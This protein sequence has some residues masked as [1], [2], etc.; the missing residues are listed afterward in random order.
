MPDVTKL[1]HENVIKNF[2]GEGH[3]LPVEADMRLGVAG[4]PESPLASEGHFLGL[5]PRL[6]SPL[7]EAKTEDFRPHFF[8]EFC[9]L[10]QSLP[11]Q[12][13]RGFVKQLKILRNIYH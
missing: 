9:N 13:L 2:L 1:M 12:F 8:V 11:S 10:P 4:A 6:L 5:K 7:L 3:H